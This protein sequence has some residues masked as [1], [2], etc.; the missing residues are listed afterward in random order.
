MTDRPADRLD[1]L[2]DAILGQLREVWTTLDRPPSDLD[3]RVSFAIDLANLDVEVARLQKE[4]LVGPGVR[5][6]ERTRTITF[7]APSLSLLVS[8]MVSDGGVRLDGWLVPAGQL[9]VELRTAPQDG[10]G[11]RVSY[12]VQADDA[13]RFAFSE[14]PHGLAQIIVYGVGDPSHT[15]VTPS[16]VL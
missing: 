6:A 1:A 10:E 16:I 14:V 12:A 9:R 15:I 3:A 8:I 7:D 5:A 4:T 13:G 11:Q 2:D